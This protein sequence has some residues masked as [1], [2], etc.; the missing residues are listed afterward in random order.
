MSPRNREDEEVHGI[1]HAVI[2]TVLTALVIGLA[3]GGA[4]LWVDVHDL[5]QDVNDLKQ[6]HE[7]YHGDD[8]SPRRNSHDVRRPN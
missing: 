6:W 3:T 7:Y 2:T 1:L 5:V 8:I 4:K